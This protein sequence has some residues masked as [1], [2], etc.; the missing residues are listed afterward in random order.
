MQQQQALAGVAPFQMERFE[1]TVGESGLELRGELA[2]RDPVA[3]VGP[4]FRKIHAALVERAGL[5]GSAGADAAGELV[6]DVRPL[7]FVSSSGLRIFLDWVS[8]IAAEPESRRYR[9][10]FRT[11]RA[12]TW[13]SAAF[14]AIVMLG[15]AHARLE[16]T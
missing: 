2:S 10:V 1:I 16:P 13:Q 4:H 15:G 14:P 3:D 5:A 8:W 6:V 9:L 11:S 12:T 7:K